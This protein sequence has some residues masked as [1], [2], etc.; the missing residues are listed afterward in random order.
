MTRTLM[1]RE[2][3]ISCAPLPAA[4]G[5]VERAKRARV[6]G[7][8]RES[9]RRNSEPADRPPHPN[10]LPARGE[11]ERVGRPGCFATVADVRGARVFLGSTIGDNLERQCSVEARAPTAALWAAPPPFSRGRMA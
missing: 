10:L 1:R 3:G 4:R 11:K 2:N 6:R 8:L 5:E 9:E 7:P